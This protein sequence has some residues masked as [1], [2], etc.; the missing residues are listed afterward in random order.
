MAIIPA[1]RR[2]FLAKHDILL[3][4]LAVVAMYGIV[5]LIGSGANALFYLTALAPIL[6]FWLR[7][8]F[9]VRRRRLDLER[10]LSEARG[11]LCTL[12]L[13]DR[14]DA[15]DRCPECGFR[16]DAAEAQVL[17]ERSGLWLRESVPNA[18]PENATL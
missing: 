6:A 7:W 13:Y 14:T 1:C 5:L 15:G 17:W 12:C 16:E 8:L 2:A 10:R 4:V 3:G 11:R 18:P 9:V